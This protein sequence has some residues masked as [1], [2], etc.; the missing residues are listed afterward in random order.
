MS[1]HAALTMAGFE[2]EANPIAGEQK[3]EQA[4]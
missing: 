4:E 1:H 3:Y 2:C